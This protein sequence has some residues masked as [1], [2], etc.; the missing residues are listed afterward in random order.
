MI[1]YGSDIEKSRAEARRLL[2][3]AGQEN[4]EFELL[5]RNVDQPY[6]IIGTWLVDEWSKVGIKATQRV[7]PIEPEF[8][9]MRSGNFTVVL[10]ANCEQVVNPIADVGRF[11]RMSSSARTTA[12]APTRKR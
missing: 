4:L 3:E 11:L 7:V 12:I 5:N 2:M 10:Q 1:G 9:A 6:K 8:D